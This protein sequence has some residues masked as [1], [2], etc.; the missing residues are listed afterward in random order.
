MVAN[1][2]L[3]Q[4]WSDLVCLDNN[5]KLVAIVLNINIFYLQN[6]SR[7]FEHLQNAQKGFL[8]IFLLHKN[9]SARI[10]SPKFHYPMENSA[11]LATI[12]ARHQC[13]DHPNAFEFKTNAVPFLIKLIFM[14][15]FSCSMHKVAFHGLLQNLSCWSSNLFLV[16]THFTITWVMP[17]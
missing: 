7:R 14:S 5:M 15:L 12:I 11:Q 4:E 6:I 13:Q 9:G 3:K 2:V 16:S 8:S 10:I 1:N 17:L